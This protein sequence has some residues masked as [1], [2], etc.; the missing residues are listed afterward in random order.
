MR[1][2]LHSFVLLTAT[3]T[4]L[5]GCRV[6]S[7]KAIELFASGKLPELLAHLANPPIPEDL[8]RRILER[9]AVDQREGTLRVGVIDNGTDYM[10]PYL[11]DRVAFQTDGKEITAAGLD[12]M[13]GDSWAHPNVFDPSL[14]A[15]GA[16]GLDDKK[17]IVEPVE[18][19]FL[20]YHQMNLKFMDALTRAIAAHPTLSQTLFA[21]INRDSFSLTGA[22]Y[23][24]NNEST[25]QFDPEN[26][27]KRAKKGQLISPKWR[28]Y[29]DPEAEPPTAFEMAEKEK[30][31][32]PIVD[33]PWT[34]GS[35]VGLPRF[36]GDDE[37]DFMSLYRVEGADTF[38]EV[39]RKTF[40]AF[41]KKEGFSRAMAPLIEFQR[42]RERST[43]TDEDESARDAAKALH[44]AWF[45]M[46]RGYQSMDPMVEYVWNLRNSLPYA[47]QVFLDG[48]APLAE[49][50]DW[51][52]KKVNEYFDLTKKTYQVLLKDGP[53]STKDMIAI[54]RSLEQIETL[55]AEFIA[56]L[57][58]RGWDVLVTGPD[59]AMRP[60]ADLYANWGY[61]V[62]DPSYSGSAGLVKQIE[63]VHLRLSD[64]NELAARAIEPL[65]A[66]LIQTQRDRLL[67]ELEDLESLQR[68]QGRLAGSDD[69]SHGTHTASTIISQDT[70]G[71]VRVYPIRVLTASNYSTAIR[72]YE[73]SRDFKKGF[74]A[75]IDKNP[76]V[77]KAIYET[78]KTIM[79]GETQHDVVEAVHREVRRYADLHIG[80]HRLD[81]EFLEEV[82][83][84]I[85][86]L[87]R[88]K[89]KVANISLGTN[90]EDVPVGVD[91]NSVENWVDAMSKFLIYEYF[92]WTLAAEAK[93]HAPHTLIFVAAGNDGKWL[94]GKTRSALPADLSSPWLAQYESKK[95]G[96]APNNSYENVAS[97]MSLDPDGNPSNFTNLP[98]GTGKNTLVVST[99]GESVLAAIK[100]TDLKGAR[101]QFQLRLKAPFER[102]IFSFD[103]SSD[104]KLLVKLGLLKE[105]Q[106][107]D[108]KGTRVRIQATRQLKA[109]LELTGSAHEILETT[110][111]L[112]GGVCDARLSGTSMATPNMVG[113]TA[114]LISEKMAAD[115]LTEAQIYDHPD[116][117]PAALKKL[118]TAN[119]KRLGQKLL[120]KSLRRLADPLEYKPVKQ[121]PL[122]DPRGICPVA[123]RRASQ[124]KMK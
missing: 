63:T 75:W 104:L 82:K 88:Q 38:F 84:A 112:S 39:L 50:I 30:E 76:L 14:F 18:D 11:V 123:I 107:N 71:R 77:Q 55:R 113:Y 62:G 103:N 59:Y 106:V 91:P 95:L 60:R 1:K 32:R 48:D 98:L 74:A 20:T 108:P 54:Q 100:T 89:I 43:S 4:I 101:D 31:M 47:D 6:Y 99:R 115:G 8:K 53:I 34:M 93:E 56:Y 122:G 46:S 124:L 57:D 78:S 13:G 3:L 10:H 49:K 16:K 109:I 81:F 97:V 27:A 42:V 119:L 79:K 80:E 87:G 7:Q 35:S 61:K 19:P 25:Y 72:D 120:I 37:F 5:V 96:K 69:E 29:K 15:F 92:K 33:M 22:F 114:S 83:L 90:F 70:T 117:S 116:Y 64:L 41:D 23:I 85:R 65:Q 86:E 26:Y 44:A 24:L 66:N 17:R 45:R 28:E 118:L 40:E 58:Q 73:V 21:K 67:L 9:L 121:I 36:G 102:R 110:E 111:C 94:D 2:I 105:D 52:K 51:A 68:R 12:V